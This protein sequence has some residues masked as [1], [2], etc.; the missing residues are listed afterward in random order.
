[1]NGAYPSVTPLPTCVRR[2][3][4]RDPMTI[5]ELVKIALDELYDEAHEL[6]GKVLDE[7]I[8]KKMAYLSESFSQ[9]NSADR[10]PVDYKDPATRFAYVYKYVAAHGDYVVQ[11]K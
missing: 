9:L 8:L 7:T 6:Y 11:V 10:K 4:R 5:F 1:M 3:E 2:A